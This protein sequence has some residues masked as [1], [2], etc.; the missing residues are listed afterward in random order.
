MVDRI[1]TMLERITQ[2]SDQGWSLNT[3]PDE[4]VLESYAKG[5]LPSEFQLND[6]ELNSLLH[7]KP[8]R[9][10]R[11]AVRA[12]LFQCHLCSNAVE[13]R[14]ENSFVQEKSP[15]ISWMKK[16][17]G[18][19]TFRRFFQLLQRPQSLIWHGAAFVIGSG[20]VYLLNKQ[21]LPESNDLLDQLEGVSA[22]LDDPPW[23][24]TDWWPNVVGTLSAIL[25]L[26]LLFVVYQLLRKKRNL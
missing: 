24:E 7:G 21:L 14:S 4:E 23:W 10:S 5:N 13:Q 9:W 11:A 22:S 17:L 2:S 8:I 12:H 15:L 20:T 1:D 19:S 16:H 18:L 3:H 6:E 26:H 25:L